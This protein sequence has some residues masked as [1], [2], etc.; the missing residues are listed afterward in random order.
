[1]I[2][3]LIPVDPPP[4]VHGK[5]A[6]AILLL[7]LNHQAQEDQGGGCKSGR[8]QLGAP[9]LQLNPPPFLD[10]PGG[11]AAPAH[12][13]FQIQIGVPLRYEHGSPSSRE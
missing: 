1:M 9:L 13:I 6:S 12:A 4:E 5:D 7:H 2:N 10:R 11:Q 3:V 8:S